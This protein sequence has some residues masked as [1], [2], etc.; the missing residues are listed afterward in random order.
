M[1]H[2]TWRRVKH[3]TPPLRCPPKAAEGRGGACSRAGEWE[4]AE[5]VLERARD[6]GLPLNHFAYS[7]VIDACERANRSDAAMRV[8]GLGVRDGAIAHW[9]EE[10]R[11]APQPTVCGVERRDGDAAGQAG[12]HAGGRLVAGWWACWWQAGGHA[13]GGTAMHAAMCTTAMT[14]A[15]IT[16]ASQVL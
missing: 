7:H 12:G 8:Y 16:T 9:M 14:A 13:G 6:S 2:E 15:T 5:A 11:P 3:P 4:R 1:P 10:V